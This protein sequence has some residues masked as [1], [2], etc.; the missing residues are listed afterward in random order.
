MQGE[1]LKPA[2]SNLCFGRLAN[3]DTQPTAGVGSEMD[4]LRDLNLTNNNQYTI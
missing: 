4:G 2:L 1:T 3:K